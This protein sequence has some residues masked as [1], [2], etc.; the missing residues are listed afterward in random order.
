MTNR[1]IAFGITDAAVIF[2]ALHEWQAHLENGANHYEPERQQRLHARFRD[3]KAA[4]KLAAKN[5]EIEAVEHMRRR[6]AMHFRR[7]LDAH[8][9]NP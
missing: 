2:D 9:A 3:K 1:R 7:L 4:E 8:E 6:I 5:K